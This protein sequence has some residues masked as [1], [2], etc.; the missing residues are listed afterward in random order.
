MDGNPAP[1][2]LATFADA[3]HRDDFA[4]TRRMKIPTIGLEGGTWTYPDNVL[5]RMFFMQNC[6]ALNDPPFK[7]DETFT[8]LRYWKFL[9]ERGEL[10]FQDNNTYLK[11]ILNGTDEYNLRR[12][13][14]PDGTPVTDNWNIFLDFIEERGNGRMLV[15]RND[16]PEEDSCLLRGV[17]TGVDEEWD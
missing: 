12:I 2:D 7:L 13:I 1:E 10:H 8:Q 6:I 14:A 16:E 11:P 15:Y 4:T 9:D 5:G 17:P 3:Y